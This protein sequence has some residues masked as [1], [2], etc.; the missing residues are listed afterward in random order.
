MRNFRRQNKYGNRKTCLNGRLF[1][2]K[3]EAEYLYYAEA[4]AVE[5]G[6]EVHLQ[7]RLK[8]TRS[9]KLNDWTIRPSHYVADYAFYKNGE[10]VRIV[11]VKGFETAEFKLKAKMVAEKYGI[12]VEI[13]KRQ[14]GG[15]THYP[16][17]APKKHR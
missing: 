9:L 12:V 3:A 5:N 1:D 11:D 14:R 16:F 8:L 15:F 6:C 10:L 17:N 7:E 13:A 2:S 4:W